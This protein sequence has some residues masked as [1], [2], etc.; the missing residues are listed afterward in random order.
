MQVGSNRNAGHTYAAQIV[1][2]SYPLAFLDLDADQM[3][4][5]DKDVLFSAGGIELA[6][7]ANDNRI[8]VEI[9]VGAE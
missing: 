6:V 9:I 1:T 5:K 3:A 8:S 2:C 7:K 4:V